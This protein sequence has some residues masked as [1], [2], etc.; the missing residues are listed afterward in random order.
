MIRSYSVSL[1][2]MLRDYFISFTT[3][4]PK[5]VSFS[6]KINAIISDSLQ[7]KEFITLRT[8]PLRVANV[9]LAQVMTL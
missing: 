6:M 1:R 3:M 8:T 4:F 2:S 9:N 7:I 5:E